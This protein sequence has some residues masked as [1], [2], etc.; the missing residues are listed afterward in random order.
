MSKDAL[1]TNRAWSA[2]ELKCKLT[3]N[4]V[5]IICFRLSL[6]RPGA[7]CW[8]HS[9]RNRKENPNGFTLLWRV[10]TLWP[11][12]LVQR[13]LESHV[14][15]LAV[16][17]QHHKWD[18]WS[19]QLLVFPSWPAVLQLLPLL[20]RT[21]PVN[22]GKLLTAKHV[23]EGRYADKPSSQSISFIVYCEHPH[24][25]RSRLGVFY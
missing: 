20:P 15:S 25:S 16:T 3:H 2:E 13:H 12:S 24:Q 11:A 18:F 5:E 8:R 22:G 6:W 17:A 7:S 23:T 21:C 10:N 9:C 4:P 14:A 19:G 1:C